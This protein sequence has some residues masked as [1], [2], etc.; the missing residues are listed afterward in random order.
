MIVRTAAVS[1]IQSALT[2][3]E[4]ERQFINDLNV[5]PVPDGDTGTNLALTARAVVEELEQSEVSD[6]PSVAAAVTKGSLMGAR[7]NS[8]VILSQIVR[9]ICEVWGQANS[10]DTAVFKRA[11]LEGQHAAY[12]AVKTPVEGTMLTVIREMATAAQA[13]PDGLGLEHLLAAVEEAGRVAVEN[14]TSQLPA[15]QKAGVVDAGGYGLLVLFRGLAAG[16]EDLMRGGKIAAGARL[17]TRGF[18]AAVK[19]RLQPPERRVVVEEPSELSEFRYCTSFL[20]SGERIDREGFEAF[21]LPIGESALVVG[22]ERTVK[23]HV[24]VN[25][26]GVVLSEA[27]KHGAISDVEIN[28]MHAQTRERDER[29]SSG[30]PMPALGEG[31]CVVVAVVAG[32]GN[33]KLFRDLGCHAI[34]DGGQSMNPSAAQLLEAV[35]ALGAE[36]V[37]ILPNNGNVILTAEQAAGMSPLHIAVVPSRSIPSGLAAM[38]AYD[39]GEDAVG[40][41]RAMQDAIAD[42]RY[43]EVTHAVR[44]SELDGLEV[45]KGQ[46]MGIVDGRLVAAAD[47]IEGAFGGVLEEFARGGAEYVTVLT[48]LNGSSGT[49]REQLEA[50]AATT[51]P[52]AEVSF[53]EGGQPLYPILASAE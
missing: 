52:D 18:G 2:A 23:V 50:I 7:G 49:T 34:V 29:L 16:I 13:V 9:G 39:P 41:A 30:P 51:A 24:H 37:V 32:D 44:D 4:K 47:D 10:L 22:D 5:Y 33:R 28:D 12:R 46:A 45:K 43:A 35:E 11:V 42:V 3:V 38:V 21:L 14:T 36:E 31:G 1:V 26:P 6:I 40:N 27:L 25:D 8:G 48:A 17:A 15:L 19:T 53:H 20:I